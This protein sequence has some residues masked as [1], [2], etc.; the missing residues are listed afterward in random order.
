ML[1]LLQLLQAKNQNGIERGF[2]MD[3][4]DFPINMNP[5]KSEMELI[6]AQDSHDPEDVAPT[7]EVD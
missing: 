7:E 6:M 2:A 4:E 1:S 5:T 3:I